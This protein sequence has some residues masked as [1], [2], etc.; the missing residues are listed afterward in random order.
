MPRTKSL[1]FTIALLL[2]ANLVGCSGRVGPG[3]VEK[4]NANPL[5]VAIPDGLSE[6]QI[7]SVM[8]RTL[9]ARGWQV[10]QASPQQTDG[11]LTWWPTTASSAFSAI[12]NISQ[13]TRGKSSLACPWVGWTT[14]KRICTSV[15]P[16]PLMSCESLLRKIAIY[17]GDRIEFCPRPS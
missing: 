11:A 13:G 7:E 12:P 2:L 14:C 5:T 16:P 10:T 6:E 8:K 1:M 15:W 9:V 17:G 3:S 4:Y